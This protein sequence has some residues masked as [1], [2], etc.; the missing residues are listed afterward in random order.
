MEPTQKQFLTATREL[1][2]ETTKFVLDLS[3][4][5]DCSHFEALLLGRAI[6]HSLL[7]N[8]SSNSLEEFKEFLAKIREIGIPL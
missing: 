1:D 6:L 7:D 4:K 3:Q 5:C 8:L 2:A